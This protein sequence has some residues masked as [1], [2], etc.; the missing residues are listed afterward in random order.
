MNMDN[1]SSKVIVKHQMMIL[2]E[3]LSLLLLGMN[4]QFFGH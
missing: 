2:R 4:N 3:V 1:K